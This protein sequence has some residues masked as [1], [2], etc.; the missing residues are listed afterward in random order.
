MRLDLAAA[1]F[2]VAPPQPLTDEEQGGVAA[3]IDDG[4]V[5]VDWLPHARLDRAALATADNDGTD[6]EDAVR[7]YAVR[8]AMHTALGTI[9]TGFRHTI[10]RQPHSR[11]GH[12]IGQPPT[13]PNV[14][15]QSRA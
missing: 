10:R 1:G 2:L 5:V 11:L 8:N 3:Y 6:D 4:Q 12:I 7:Y 14:Q 13:T 9:L 15:E